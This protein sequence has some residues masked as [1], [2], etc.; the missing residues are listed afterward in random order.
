MKQIFGFYNTVKQVNPNTFGGEGAK[1]KG[2]RKG[3]WEGKKARAVRPWGSGLE[4]G[5]C[6]VLGEG[7]QLHTMGLFRQASL[8]VPIDRV[9]R[10]RNTSCCVFWR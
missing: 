8:S 1:K 2:G 9:G 7:P 3:G 5:T 6:H 4:P 10:L